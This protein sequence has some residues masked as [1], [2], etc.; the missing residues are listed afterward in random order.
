MVFLLQHAQNRDSAAIQLKLDELIR[1]SRDLLGR[2]I[3]SGDL[4]EADLDRLAASI[5]RLATRAEARS[6]DAGADLP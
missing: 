2:P 4:S 5:A 3:A 1:V 6:R